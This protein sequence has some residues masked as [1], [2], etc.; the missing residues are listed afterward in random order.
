MIHDDRVER[1]RE[2]QQERIRS[3]KRK[4]EHGPTIGAC[5][6]SAMQRKFEAA[7]ERRSE[8][9]L[10]WYHVK[11]PVTKPKLWS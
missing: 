3:R 1:E 7:C 8:E 11:V 2:T 6:M 10:L 4:A 9:T 5:Y